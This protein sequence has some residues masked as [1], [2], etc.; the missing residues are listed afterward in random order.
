MAYTL[1]HPQVLQGLEELVRKGGKVRILADKTCAESGT[2]KGEHGFLKELEATGAASTGEAQIRLF[3]AQPRRTSGGGSW[4]P[5]QLHAK[6]GI[7]DAELP[8]ATAWVGSLNLTE[9]SAGYY[10]VVAVVRDAASVRDLKKVFDIW[11]EKGVA[12]DA[13]K[14]PAPRRSPSAGRGSTSSSELRASSSTRRSSKSR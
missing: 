12:F 1:D 3:S 13:Q 9:N 14:I 4:F 7:V 10:E 5:A 8:E 11:W 6:C 2:P